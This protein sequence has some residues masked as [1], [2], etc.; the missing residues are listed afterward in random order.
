[1]LTTL[2]LCGFAPLMTAYFI[3]RVIRYENTSETGS[4]QGEKREIFPPMSSQTTGL[5]GRY[6]TALYELADETKSLD[7]VAADLTTLRQLITDSDDLSRLVRSP[8]VARAD[9]VK[10][11]TAVLEAANANPLTVKFVS[12]AADN[13]RLYAVPQMITAFLAELARRRGEVQA[14]V[15]SAVALNKDEVAAVMESLRAAVG[16]KVAVNLTVDPSLIGGLIVRVG[17]RMVDSSLRSKINRLQLSM[18]GVG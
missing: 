15:T 5:A 6:A 4:W 13:R 12:T 17:S 18:K 1:M 8:I 11:M 2:R 14:D 3:N 9:Q 7:A 10:G 16:Q